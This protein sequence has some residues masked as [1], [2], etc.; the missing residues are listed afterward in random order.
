[1]QGGLSLPTRFETEGMHLNTG[2][3]VTA[4]IA[5]GGGTVAVAHGDGCVRLFAGEEPVR[6]IRAHHGAVLAMSAIGEQA[7]LTGG[8]DGRCLRISAA[9]D[10]EELADFSGTWVDCVAA[11][12]AG[13]PLACSAGR[14]VH[15]WRDGSTRAQVLEHPSTVGGLAFAPKGQRLAVA[16][17]GGA[18]IWQPGKRGWKSSR[19]AWAG[20]HIGVTWSPDGKYVVTVMQE[21]ALHGWRVRDKADMRMS[22]YPAKPRAFDWIGN[23]PHLATSGADQVVCWPFQSRDGP[24]GKAPLCVADGAGQSV[25][26]VRGLPGCPA[27][28]AGFQD[29]S[30]L[31]SELE[32]AAEPRM[33]RASTGVEVTAIAVTQSLSHILIGDANGTVLW[34]PLQAPGRN[35]PLAYPGQSR[36]AVS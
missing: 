27:V 31:V 30:V 34:A 5:L 9:G 36:H 21:N 24:M 22:G 18:T 8:D 15:L 20:S 1:M 28:I 4:A 12:G 2:A 25:T 29:G 19:L 14:E 6:L 16:H 32:E 26:M 10:V 35:A 17:Y 11:H 23:G 7:V 3:P 13:G 33:L